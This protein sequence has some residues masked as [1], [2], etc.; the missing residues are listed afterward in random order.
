MSTCQLIAV[1]PLGYDLP[2]P[3]PLK[4]ED[5]A[6]I[7]IH[8]SGVSKI[9]MS[10]LRVG[11]LVAP[12][13]LRGQLLM[14]RRAADLCNPPL[15]QRAV[16]EF[17]RRGRLKTHLKH[18]VPLYAE[19]RNT[20]MQTLG[21]TMPHYVRWTYPLG[22]FSCWL[23]IPQDKIAEDLHKEALEYGVAF[24]PGE[25]FSTVSDDDMHLRLCFGNQPPEVIREVVVVLS[26][27]IRSHL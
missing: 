11:Y 8:L 6:G 7:V 25:V 18:V 27:L 12:E 14:L 4:S 3:P 21:A 1:R 17:I 9:M 10:G 13:P 2:P 26:R 20:L 16:A 19:R 15:V 5:Y 24:T 23:S 22:G